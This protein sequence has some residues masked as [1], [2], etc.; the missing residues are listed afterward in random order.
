MHDKEQYEV[1]KTN[2]LISSRSYKTP[3]FENV[4]PV[5]YACPIE[6]SCLGGMTAECSK[7]YTGP[8]CAVCNKGYYKVISQCRRCPSLPWIIAQIFLVVFIVGLIIAIIVWEKKRNAR[9]SSRSLADLF[10]ARL[11]IVIG[12]Y[13][14]SSST[15]DAFSY[16]HWPST[17]RTLMDY[18]KMVQLNLFQLVPLSCIKDTI[19]TDAYLK[20]LFSIIV[21]GFI[22]L[23]WSPI[24]LVG[25]VL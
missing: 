4:I 2:L 17:V 18:A 8:L 1:F 21:S 22:N 7:G 3:K 9:T 10:L 12:F 25:E 16:I 14:V 13:Q 15:F 19:K 20:F 6:D 23:D 11:K 5:A 24:Q